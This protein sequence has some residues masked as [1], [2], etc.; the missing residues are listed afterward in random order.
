MISD[1]YRV[2]EQLVAR[3]AHNQEVGGSS[4]SRAT[5]GVARDTMR[6]QPMIPGPVQSRRYS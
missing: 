5:T 1:S 2:V 6:Q 3:L 4:P